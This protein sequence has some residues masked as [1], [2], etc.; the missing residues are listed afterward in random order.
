MTTDLFPRFPRINVGNVGPHT[1]WWRLQW[2]VS[3][4]PGVLEYLKGTNS[5][6][7]EDMVFPDRHVSQLTFATTDRRRYFPSM[8]FTPPLHRAN[9]QWTLTEFEP[10]IFQFSMEFKVEPLLTLRWGADPIVFPQSGDPDENTEPW[11]QTNTLRLYDLLNPSRWQE[12]KIIPHSY[13]WW[14]SPYRPTS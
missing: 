14:D 2:K 7:I 10:T 8:G 3:A 12:Y 11:R 1:H 4:L 9:V 5:G 6:N 13:C